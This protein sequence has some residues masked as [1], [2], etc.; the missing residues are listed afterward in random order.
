MY[1]TTYQC[2]YREV[3]VFQTTLVEL[4]A[5]KRRMGST[6]PGKETV[7]LS[8]LKSEL[9]DWRAAETYG[10]LM[11]AFSQGIT[12]LKGVFSH[13]PFKGSAENTDEVERGSFDA[14]TLRIPKDNPNQRE[15]YIRS[16]LKDMSF[17]SPLLDAL[18]TEAG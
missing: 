11:K 16:F 8:S 10:G 18:K 5:R 7:P 17:R 14:V 13:Y 4:I 6:S 15:R 2:L 3:L 1:L 9:G 12:D